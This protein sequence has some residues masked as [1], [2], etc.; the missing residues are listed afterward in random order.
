M[1]VPFKS[2]YKGSV[3]RIYGF[4][5]KG[6]FRGLGLTWARKVCRIEA[7]YRC[8]AVMLPASAG[9]GIGFLFRPSG[10]GFRTLGLVSGL[11]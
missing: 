3:L 9:L 4:W 5:V 10:S 11:M 1:R 8:W 7:F 2:V 6:K